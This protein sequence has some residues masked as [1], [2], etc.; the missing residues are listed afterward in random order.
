MHRWLR[1]VG[2][3]W[4]VWRNNRRVPYEIEVQQR[5]RLATLVEFAR[6]N[7]LYYKKLYE[8]LPATIDDTS[9][10]P[11]VTK[12]DLMARFDDWVTDPAVTL[13]GVKAFLADDSLVGQLFLDKYAACFTSG[14]TGVRGSFLQDQNSMMVG[15]ALTLARG[16]LSL[17]GLR[18]SRVAGQGSRR[19]NAS[20]I[21]TGGHYATYSIT[22]RV[23]RQFPRQAKHNRT[24]SVLTPLPDLVRELNEFQPSVLSGYPNAITVLAHEKEAGRLRIRPYLVITFSETLDELARERITETFGCVV[25]SWYGAAEAESIAYDCGQGWLHLNSDWVILEPVD[26]K[27]RPVPPGQ[28]SDTVLLTNLA[29]R[30]QPIIRYDL[31]DR[32]VFKPERCLCGSPLPAIRIAGRLHDIPVFT[33]PE[34]E[35]HKMMPVL[36]STACIETPG[37]QR[38]QV[39]QTTPTR[40]T[41]RFEPRPGENKDEVWKALSMRLQGRLADQGLSFVDLVLDPDPPRTDPR[42]GKFRTFAVEMAEPTVS[43]ESTRRKQG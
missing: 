31:G 17:A 29:N 42:S 33:S 10:L 5:A 40:L 43:S 7:S 6:A 11:T 3:V 1:Q 41:V 20:V 32:I 25:R 16:A 27:H 28:E 2:T 15:K 8:K 39:V 23:R 18:K 37:V 38:H 36:L 13:D 12:Q 9:L 14:T 34:G 24:F 19:L 4:S 30:V 35:Q 21:A 22:E 26:E